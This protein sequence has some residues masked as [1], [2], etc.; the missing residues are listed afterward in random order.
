MSKFN[1]ILDFINNKL[2]SHG[3][4]QIDKPHVVD[5][6]DV[7]P[8]YSSE[9]LDGMHDKRFVLF[10][11]DH[12]P[13]LTKE[14]SNNPDC[15]YQTC[16]GDALKDSSKCPK[17]IPVMLKYFGKAKEYVNNEIL[18]SRICNAMGVPTV[19]NTNYTDG[20]QEYLLSV[21]FLPHDERI[22]DIEEL[23]Y[24]IKDDTYF[25]MNY[26]LNDE[27][28]ISND[29]FDIYEV[30]HMN[31]CRSRDNSWKY[32]KNKYYADFVM[33]YLVRTYILKDMDSFP[34]NCCNI[35]DAN[36]NMRFGPM[37]DCEIAFAKNVDGSD[38]I[39]SVAY[40]KKHYPQVFEKFC[41]KYN[42]LMNR[43]TLRKLF[44]DI[45][46]KEYVKAKRKYLID[47]YDNF[48]EVCRYA[49]YHNE[50]ERY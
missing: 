27:N 43:S 21:D 22:V 32:D 25:N 13:G 16:Y 46:N 49:D 5:F 24:E 36:N 17:Y 33:H 40:I 15:T 2:K 1:D 3:S 20:D 35:I 10:P 44:A 9:E 45:D 26:L 7:R 41:Q 29:L 8:R 28:N 47:C 30:L 23:V 6:D 34:K 39:V 48:A 31:K 42:A 37:Y 11:I 12:L 19:Y 38:S 18:S 14:L 4:A 50:N